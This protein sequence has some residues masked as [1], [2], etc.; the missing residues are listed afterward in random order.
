M[1]RNSSKSKRRYDVTGFTLVELVITIAVLAILSGIGALGY[2]GYITK[3]N[4]A[5]D[6]ALL[7]AVNTAFQSAYTE[8]EVSGYPKTAEATLDGS[9]GALKLR[10][11]T[12]S[13]DDGTEEISGFYSMFQKYFEGNEDAVF[14]V[15][16]G[17]EYGVENGIFSG[18]LGNGTIVL[19][20]GWK[21]VSE[22]GEP[23]YTKYTV[24]D[25][26]GNEYTFIAKDSSVA[27]LNES[28][29][30]IM[31][32]ANVVSEVGACADGAAA[33]FGQLPV[34]ML[35]NADSLARFNA[36]ISAHHLS[37][38]MDEY[39]AAVS[40]FVIMDVA[41]LSKD[42]AVAD[43]KKII[44]G[45]KK[46]GTAQ[47]GQRVAQAAT[48]YGV[49]TAWA[50][51]PTHKNDVIY[52]SYTAETLWN[53]LSEGLK[54]GDESQL[55]TIRTEVLGL[56]SKMADSSGFDTYIDSTEGQ[57]AIEAYIGAMGT[58]Y[59]NTS[60]LDDFDVYAKGF[61]DEDLGAIL[62]GV[63]GAGG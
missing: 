57:K 12:A 21:I 22:A 18:V 38:G 20:N 6:L 5:H 52:G 39:D 41:T 34:N 61:N 23:G 60:T 9:D 28:V 7:G 2:S 33:T 3:A 14:K 48:A 27:A 46:L 54:S 4:E 59:D 47:L 17:L 16:T 25:D 19:S 42:I 58:L 15:Y 31:G 26:A 32:A 35:L 29:F 24:T 37:K 56:A 11:L 44:E 55:G 51:D 63:Y 50:H 1:A 30:G 13:N 45:D 36:Y 49:L 62:S 43:T 10:N 8:A 40:N 53:H